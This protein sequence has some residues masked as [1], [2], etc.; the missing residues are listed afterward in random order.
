M[1][2]SEGS[3]LYL[4]W[5]RRGQEYSGPPRSSARAAFLFNDR[6]AV[7]TVAAEISSDASEQKSFSKS[8]R[9]P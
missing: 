9:D 2:S 8:A 1:D 7:S 6:K 3:A 4:H 5:T